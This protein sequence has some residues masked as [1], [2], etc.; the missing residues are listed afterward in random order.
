MLKSPVVLSCIVLLCLCNHTF[1]NEKDRVKL[2][3]KWN[4]QFQFAGYYAALEKGFYAEQNIDL[5]ILNLILL[6][7]RQ[8]QFLMVKQNLGWRI[9][10]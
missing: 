6:N 3:L 9:L 4:T 5:T 10:V 1:A 2:Q 8:I 7:P